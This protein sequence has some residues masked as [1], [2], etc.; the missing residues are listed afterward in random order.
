MSD[1]G[2]DTSTEAKAEKPAKSP[3]PI[4]VILG[5]LNSLA[6]FGLLGILVYTKILYKKP[7][8]TES[9]E[10]EKVIE[11]Y[12][13]APA[14]G[15][16][17]MVV[18]D[19]MQANLKASPIGVQVPGG[20]PQQMKP[21]YATMTIALELISNEY[22]SIAKELL[23][24]FLDRILRELGTTSVEE[25]SSVQGRYLLRSKVAGIMNE[26]IRE[27]KNLAPNSEPAVANVY[28]SDFVVQ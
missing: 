18:F 13:K 15:E 28:F 6:L 5:A 23:P 2:T 8:I 21:H 14:A 1:A 19:P 22:A 11:E 26:L 25:L 20:P 16:R 12:A 7:H 17:T 27:A 24:K 3:P 10:R 9:A 4:G